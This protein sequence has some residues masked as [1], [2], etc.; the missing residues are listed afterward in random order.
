M[1]RSSA[2]EPKTVV[3]AD[4]A[5]LWLSLCLKGIGF[6]PIVLAKAVLTIKQFHSLHIFSLVV[7]GKY[8]IHFAYRKEEHVWSVMQ[9]FMKIAVATLHNAE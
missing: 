2:I 3:H 6:C 4:N 9:S 5:E 8:Q 1:L 7:S